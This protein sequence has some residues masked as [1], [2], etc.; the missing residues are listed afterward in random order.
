MNLKSRIHILLASVVVF[1][2]AC[3]PKE[4]ELGTIDLA[5][6]DLKLGTAFSIEADASN[7]NII[8]LKSL[9]D[10]KYT[11]LWKHPQGRS[12]EQTVALTIPFPGTYNVQLGAE[13]RGG[14]VYGEPASFEI[15]TFFEEAVSDPLWTLLTGGV[16]NEKTWVWNDKIPACF[17][18]GGKG[19]IYPEW[20]QVSYEGV[21][22]EAW[23]IGEM[24][25]DLKG[26]PNFTKTLNTGVTTKGLFELDVENKRLTILDANILHGA[27]Y[28]D[29]GAEGKYYVITNITET[30]MTLARQGDGWQNTW[31]FRVK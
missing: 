20:W 21:I 28:D 12:Q 27:N 30:E 19:S 23:D 29:D 6:G 4:Y 15:T 10:P 14:I 1:L 18:N 3:T 13:T 8:Y 31:V 5:P 25:F 2:S 7:P 17:G 16:D 9:L 22:S 26:A 24:V 11:P